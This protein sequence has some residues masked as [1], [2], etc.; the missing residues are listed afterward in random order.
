VR[1]DTGTLVT[2]SRMRSVSTMKNVVL[3]SF[4]VEVWAGDTLVYSLDTGFGFF[5]I[6]AFAAQPGLAV[7]DQERAWLTEAN[8]FHVD[9]RA[10]PE[11][12]CGGTLRLADPMLLMID[13][14]DGLWPTGGKQGLG[15]I[16]ARKKVNPAEWFFKAHFFQDPVQP[17][18]LGCEAMIQLLQWWMIHTEQHAGIDSPRFEIL[19]L[20]D[21]TT[22]KY[23]GQIVPRNRMIT[24][25]L[26]ILEVGTGTDETGR[27]ARA[28]AHVWVDGLRIYAYTF[29]VRIVPGGHDDRRRDAH[30][31]PGFFPA[32]REGFDAAYTGWETTPHP[33][34]RRRG[35]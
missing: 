4:D 35:S 23:R 6:D 33:V 5:P 28:L 27:F 26:D 31:G 21:A 34:T 25:E 2:K 30:S 12:Y 8:D 16:R 9:L 3:M 13:E 20:A 7:S 17:G 32:P 18:S 22:W 24:L 29:G 15:K 1:P 14:I 11:R 19:A 10:R